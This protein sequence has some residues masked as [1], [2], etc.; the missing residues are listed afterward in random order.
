MSKTMAPRA[1]LKA[2]QSAGKLS[3]L[4]ESR[5]KMAIFIC[6]TSFLKAKKKIS[7]GKESRST[8]E[9]AAIRNPNRITGCP[10]PQ[11]KF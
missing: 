10:S 11:N 5:F 6:G 9:Y 1:R 3:N 4:N 2:S 8:G 7:L